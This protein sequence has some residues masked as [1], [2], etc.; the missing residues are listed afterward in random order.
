MAQPDLFMCNNGYANFYFA[1]AEEDGDAYI[2]KG[3][4]EVRPLS[5]FYTP[6]TGDNV[7]IGFAQ[8]KTNGKLGVATYLGIINFYM[9][10]I[11]PAKQIFCVN[12]NKNF[13]ARNTLEKLQDCPQGFV[14][15][16][17]SFHINAK[18]YS[19][20]YY[21]IN[22]Y[23]LPEI[24]PVLSKKDFFS[25]TY[26]KKFDDIPFFNK[27][28][29]LTSQEIWPLKQY[30]LPDIRRIRDPKNRDKAQQQINDLKSKGYKIM[31]CTYKTGS[32][33]IYYRFW[34]DVM[35]VSRAEVNAISK[36]NPLE[37]LGNIA[38]KDCPPT[39]DKARDIHGR[40]IGVPY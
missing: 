12:F 2:L 8:E 15:T 6:L 31:E 4:N 38:L 28:H 13:K 30:K 10:D 20:P 26:I 32:G 40:S 39:H 29:P 36:E 17:F 23:M 3:W 27:Q 14:R 25:R 11:N 7:Y 19:D 35:P 22:F 16:H 5:C 21:W 9:D 18:A 37:I 34:Y 33:N 24:N 1:T